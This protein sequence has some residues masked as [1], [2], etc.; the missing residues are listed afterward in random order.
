MGWDYALSF[1]V[2]WK[3]VFIAEKTQEYKIL[4]MD[5]E[6]STSVCP[7]TCW[8]SRGP[9][10][11]RIAGP[12]RL[13]SGSV[14]RVRWISHRIYELGLRSM[15]VS[16]PTLIW[17]KP[18]TEGFVRFLLTQ[19]ATG[20]WIWNCNNGHAIVAAR[21]YLNSTFHTDYSTVEVLGRVKKLCSHFHLFDHMISISGVEWDREMNYLF[22]PQH[23]WR[24][25]RE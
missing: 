3:G 18:V 14:I 16:S 25:W 22:A 1:P 20:N 13:N 8:C 12:Q 4:K 5:S 9:I 10:K 11:I 7:P 21:E 19:K 23:Q 2:N 17:P 15:H 6:K 24:L